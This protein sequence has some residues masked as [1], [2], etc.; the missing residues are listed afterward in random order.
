MVPESLFL[1]FFVS[2]NKPKTLGD[3]KC[4]GFHRVQ[5]NYYSPKWLSGTVLAIKL[6][7]LVCVPTVIFLQDKEKGKMIVL[8]ALL[9]LCYLLLNGGSIFV[10]GRSFIS[11]YFLS[12]KLL[13]FLLLLFL[14]CKNIFKCIE[15]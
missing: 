6:T 8:L 1:N 11:L 15:E 7:Y 13:I 9:E 12:L 5:Y 4:T 14:K 10:T 3:N 2:H